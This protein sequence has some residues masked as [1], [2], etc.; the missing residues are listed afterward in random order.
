MS[1]ITI[2]TT[3]TITFTDN[4]NATLYTMTDGRDT[5]TLV[6]APEEMQVAV[7]ITGTRSLYEWNLLWQRMVILIESAR[8]DQRIDSD[9][10]VD[11][12]AIPTD[13]LCHGCKLPPSSY[14][15]WGMPCRSTQ[16]CR[17]TYYPR[18]F[19]EKRFEGQSLVS[20]KGESGNSHILSVRV[21]QKLWDASHELAQKA[22]LTHSDFVR[23]A[24]ADYL[25]RNL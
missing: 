4:N 10:L 12:E 20:I 24:L 13:T 18:S 17:G 9:K 19:V 25:E 2:P 6:G 7:A 22:G 21:P 14:Q 1:D 3:W 11:Y 5:L 8:I 15:A 16:D 23:Q